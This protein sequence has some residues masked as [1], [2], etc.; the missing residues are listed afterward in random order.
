MFI[1]RW[2]RSNRYYQNDFLPNPDLY[3]RLIEFF[4]TIQIRHLI[5]P[6]RRIEQ[7]LYNCQTNPLSPCFPN[8]SSSLDMS[9]A[10]PS[11]SD[12]TQSAIDSLPELNQ[13]NLFKVGYNMFYD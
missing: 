11:D 13:I 1:S 8:L 6:V 3:R 12:T 9:L 10:K 7:F 2:V 4:S 5:G